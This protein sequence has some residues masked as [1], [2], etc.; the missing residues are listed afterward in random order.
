MKPTVKRSIEPPRWA[1]RLLSWYCRADLLE[2]LQGDLN[3]YFERNLTSKGASRARLIYVI[4]VLK[5][6]RTYT[7]RKPN[8]INLF[9]HW[10]MLGSYLKT[11]QRSLVRNKLFSFINIFGLAVS[12]SVGLLVISFINDLLSYDDFQTKKDRTYRII[13]T[14]QTPEQPPM[15]L[16]STSVKVGQKIRERVAGVENVTI[17]RNGFGGNATVGEKTIPF[18]ALWADAS[19]FRVFTFPLLEGDSATALK[20]PYSLVLT[21]KMAKKLFSDVDPLGKTVHIDTL[22]YTVTGIAKDVPH[23][24]HLRFEALVSFATADIHM[25]R[26]DPNFYGWDNIWQNYV[27]IT[28]PEHG[29]IAPVQTILAKLNK[30]E[31]AAF[32]NRSFT[33]SL[34]PFDEIALGRRL[35]NAIGPTMI[36]LVVW[37]LVGLAVVIMLSA[38]FN[39]TNLSIARSLRRSR[40]VG[41]RKVIGALKMHVMGQFMA[42]SV[43]IALLAL[44]FSFGLFLFL[45]TQFLGLDQFISNL[46]SLNLSL[47]VILWF[48]A[49]AIVVGLVAGFLP[50]VFFARINP[51]QVI[52]DVSVLRVFRRVTMRKVLIVMQYTISL[53]FITTTIIGY[54]QYRSFLTLDLGFSTENILNIKLLGNKGD[55]LTKEL[56][57]LPA[58]TEVAKSQLV[59]S[60]GSAGGTT[61]KYKNPQDSA[62]V[63]HNMVDEHY[64]PIHKHKLLAGKNFSLRPKHGEESE[65]IVN[66]QVLKRFNIA[67]RNPQKALG[68]IVTVDG[69][70]LAIVGVLKDF[71]YE[72]VQSPIKPVMFRY[73]ADPGGYLNVKI[74]STD[75]P[76]TMAQIEKVWNKIDK[77]HPM[78]A[79]FYDD[80]IEEAYRSFS[81]ILKVIGFIA[82]LAICIA[83]LGLFGM[84]VFTTETK[85]KE[86]SIRKVLGASEEK[87]VFTLSKGL[88]SLLAVSALVALPITYLFFTNV[89]LTNFAYHQPIGLSDLLIG[90]LIVVLVAMVLIG[91]QTLKAARVNPAHVLKSE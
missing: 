10:I 67:H 30:Q 78:E 4:D 79:K 70:K 31:N 36:P 1:Q 25:A 76:A 82:F 62:V 40:E 68:E 86:I 43:I 23:L 77:V 39:Y 54:S 61:M 45:R 19:F 5:F 28:L 2:D 81:V 75:L 71:H 44:V 63:W 91:S 15:D 11:S 48:I 22:D 60:L 57:S 34:Q 17:L 29:N 42:E 47:R 74:S 53:I 8:F 56:A 66:E 59:T 64:L 33:V 85:L 83:S 46:V 9:I 72:T 37:I 24:S 49:L 3:E 69:K 52:K 84:V 13:S 32:K 58:V 65:I 89:V 21:E 55:V 51:I 73:S 14:Y 7:V 50:A 87:L 12:M 90:S 18:D 20:D 38:C 35:Q 6:F 26:N 80:Q 16:A 41:I 88:L 27:Y